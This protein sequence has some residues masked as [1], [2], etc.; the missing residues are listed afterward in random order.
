MPF[1]F[2]LAAACESPTRDACRSRLS[3]NACN[4]FS[5]T[6]MSPSPRL[7]HVFRVLEV[8]QDCAD[9]CQHPSLLRE[10]LLERFS[11]DHAL[12]GV[13]G[14]ILCQQHEMEGPNKVLPQLP[15]NLQSDAEQGVDLVAG[16][17]LSLHISEANFGKVRKRSV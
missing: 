10:V 12:V 2:S 5:H 3:L 11:F 8:P 7:R 6:R 14:G 4:T 9:E 17:G 13:R 16:N 15:R 1:R